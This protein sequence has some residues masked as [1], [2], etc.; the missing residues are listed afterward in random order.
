MNARP[1]SDWT[2]TAARPAAAVVVGGACAL[3]CLWTLAGGSSPWMND[4]RSPAQS[5]SAAQPSP[6]HRG[7]SPAVLIDLNAATQ[8]ELES[9]PGVGP[10][11]AERIIAD[12]TAHGAFAT[13]DALDRVPGIGKRTIDRLRDRVRA[14]RG[15][16]E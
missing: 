16:A 3:L 11:L 4:E 13:V 6:F 1:D 8:A 7:I 15:P 10:A 5:A 9:L 14:G 12:R 2:S